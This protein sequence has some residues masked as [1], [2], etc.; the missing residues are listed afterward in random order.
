MTQQGKI[1]TGALLGATLSIPLAALL[2]LGF[3][4]AGLPMLAFDIFEGLTRIQA[5][6]GLVTKAIDLMVTVF[7]SIP[8]AATDQLAKG[9]EQLSAVAL[10]VILGAIGGAIFALNRDRMG[11]ATALSVGLVTLILALGVEITIRPGGADALLLNG[12]WLAVLIIGWAY[13]LDWVYDRLEMR[14]IPPTSTERRRFLLQLGGGLVGLTV[15]AWGAGRLLGQRETTISTSSAGSG[16]PIA[17]GPTVTPQS[18]QAAVGT[19]NSVSSNAFVAAPGTRAELTSNDNFYR[20]DV[21]LGA[22]QVDTK[23][24]KLN[25][26]GLVNNPTTIS[27]DE[28]TKM[29]A[30]QQLATL[31]CISNPVGGDLISTTQWTGVRLS[32]ILNKAGLQDGVVEIKFTCSDG[33]TESLSM[34]AAMDERTLLVYA[35]NG[36][37]LP[38]VH[39]FPLRLYTPNRY[40]MKNPKWIT[41]IEGIRDPYDGYWEVRGWDK[42]AIVKTTSAIDNVAKD[43]A[44]NGAVPVGGIAFAGA[45]GISKV[46]IA[47]DGGDWQPAELKQPLSPLTWV[48]WRLNWQ[49]TK[50]HH[51]I[52]VRATDGTGAVQTS[53]VADLHPD[54]ASGYYSV[55]SDI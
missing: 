1:R 52:R 8:G 7:S 11:K 44:A 20:V 35:M 30:V 24:W 54:G 15:V 26:G 37:A 41:T 2:Y 5:L 48:L 4:L 31:E 43:A 21:N 50:G 55:G 13:A 29:P 32:D 19:E 33:Y 45:R 12:L 47:V 51:D 34:D 53:Q 39:G 36:M 22:P 42:Q 17:S 28:L 25:V 27:Y 46:E 9:F 3:Q 10:F 49:A 6:G 23:T 16:E 40:G 18:G 14:A 38:D